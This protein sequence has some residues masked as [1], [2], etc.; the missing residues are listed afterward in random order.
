MIRC[1]TCIAAAILIVIT[2]T[3]TPAGQ[4]PAFDVLIR[5]GRLLDGTG[6]PYIH[7]DVGIRGDTIVAVG[8]LQDATA[9]KIV[10]ARGKYVTPGFMALH[11]HL[12]GDI[13]AGR[14]GL[15]N[16][17]TQGF[18]TAVINTDGR[19]NLP[20]ARQRRELEKAGSALNTVQM[21][22][23]G[24][25]RGM[26]MGDDFMRQATTAEIDRMKQL[27]KQGMDDG[28]FGLSAGLEVPRRAAGALS[29]RC[30]S[31]PRWSHRTAAS[32]RPT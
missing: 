27:V 1:R 32:T 20:I 23:H 13:L 11:E 31:W 8:A 7:A 22:G 30:W 14:G 16:F 24:T 5:N 25:V 21:V 18:T 12:E 2:L 17:T 4:G 6:N 26:A 9:A 15:V 29:R 19:S 10:D 3:G 28:A